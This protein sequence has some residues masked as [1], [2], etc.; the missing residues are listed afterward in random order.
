VVFAGGFCLPFCLPGTKRWIRLRCLSPPY[1]FH[2][3]SLRQSKI[4][5]WRLALT[6]TPPVSRAASV[7]THAR[8]AIQLPV[9]LILPYH[10]VLPIPMLLFQSHTNLMGYSHS[11]WEM[12]PASNSMPRTLSIIPFLVRF[13]PDAHQSNSLTSPRTDTVT[14]AAAIFIMDLVAFFLSFQS[15][16]L[17]YSYPFF[18]HAY[19]SLQYWSKSYGG[20]KRSGADFGTSHVG[21]LEKRV[22]VPGLRKMQTRRKLRSLNAKRV[23]KRTKVSI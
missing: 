9:L 4:A 18:L 7:D 22:N 2:S 6:L 23:A 21:L 12:I 1:Q 3:N 19:V 20:L 11:A 5:A 15:S 17:A 10:L 13:F 8:P 14:K 16:L